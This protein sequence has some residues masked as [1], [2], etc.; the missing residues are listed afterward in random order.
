MEAA[1]TPVTATIRGKPRKI[2]ALVA[3]AM[4]LAT[5]AAGGDNRAM[6]QLLDRIEEIEARAAAAKP[7]QF[8]FT[9]GDVEVLREVHERMKQSQPLGTNEK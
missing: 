7:S 1:K 5:K 8:P 3:S 4:Q 6:E 9:P 2:S